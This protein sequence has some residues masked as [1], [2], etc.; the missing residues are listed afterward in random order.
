MKFQ[1]LIID[2]LFCRVC[3]NPKGAYGSL[4]RTKP[5][6]FKTEDPILAMFIALSEPLSNEYSDRTTRGTE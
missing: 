5:F 4:A 2:S 1:I 6:F 3:S